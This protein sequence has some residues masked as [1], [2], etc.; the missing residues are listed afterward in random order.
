MLKT[1]INS[2][3]N[4]AEIL[5]YDDIGGDF[6]RP[7]VTASQFSAELTKARGVKSL[8]LRINSEGGDVFAGYTIYNRLVEF[9]KSSTINVI[10]DG[11]AASIASVI[12]MS[13]RSIRMG[14]GA[15]MM[16]HDPWT[17]AV[18]SA[19]EFR[20]AADLLDSIKAQM[21]EVYS[22]RTGRPPADVAE[23][24]SAETWM[25]GPEA[26][27][28]KFADSLVSAP[29]VAAASRSRFPYR[30]RPV[31]LATVAQFQSLKSFLNHRI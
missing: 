25:T 17:M 19:D 26:V 6:I 23:M 21:V 16:I 22:A 7:G 24:M 14:T 30:N 31:R 5:L 29:A 11:V 2:R 13:G 10:V 3:T 1:T 9:G 15:M 8:T 20:R 27:A 4:E 28:R 18:G 12:A